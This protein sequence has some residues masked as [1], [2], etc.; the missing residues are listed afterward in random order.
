MSALQTWYS[1]TPATGYVGIQVD[2]HWAPPQA[3]G[4][5]VRTAFWSEWRDQGSPSPYCHAYWVIVHRTSDGSMVNPANPESTTVCGPQS[6][7]GLD[8]TG[9]A[10][11]SLYLDVAVD[12]VTAPART[13]RTV[14]AQLT[15]G[16]QAYL[17]KAI[18][19]YVVP[20][21][22][23]EARWTVDFGDGSSRVFPD[24]GTDSLTTT[25]AY[26]PG[27]FDVT[28][29]V[30]VT[31]EA[32]GAFFTPAGDPFE[33]V[34]PFAIDITNSASGVSA[35][36]V[37]YIA[38]VVTV[39][40]SP[41][42]TLPG[43][44]A[45]PPDD[46]GHDALW[47]PRGLH[48]L[49]YVRPIIVTEGVMRSGGTV[50]GGGTTVLLSYRYERGANDAADAT[51]HRVVPAR[52]AGRGPVGR[53]R[54][55][56]R[57]PGPRAPHHLRR[58]HRPRHDSRGRRRGHRRLRRREP[59]AERGG[60]PVRV[61]RA[62]YVVVFLLAGLVAG[63]VY[64]LGQPRVEV[65]RATVDI[66][67][68]TLVTADMVETV[69]VAP[70][71]APGDAAGSTVEVVGSY[72]AVP[73]LA[74]Q[75][76]DRRA[77]ESTPGER[78]LGFGAPLAAGQVAFALPV[79]PGQAVGAALAPGARVDVVAVPN[80]LKTGACGRPLGEPAGD[81]GLWAR[82][83]SSS[84]SGPPDGQ[85]LTT[86]ARRNAGSGLRSSR[87]SSAASSSPSRPRPR[88]SSRRRPSRRP[89]TSPSRSPGPARETRPA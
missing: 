51:A 59:L 75:A 82:A 64:L 67:V 71:D 13:D 8:G 68:M 61:R 26:E 55:V 12:P 58:R 39:G 23:R 44:T 4:R 17:G 63:G 88:P 28:V 40:A 86:G 43:G 11:M 41:S 72:A 34:V 87:R 36:P 85:P 48:C 73:I 37:D 6:V 78:A 47:W 77:L 65:V 52:L 42:G 25:H 31:G 54:H 27:T 18:S 3:K 9:C 84:P 57:A 1:P 2:G 33:Q 10:D 66:P 15:A 79:E 22:V 32:Y 50:I 5:P 29:T 20:G 30:H 35:L 89:S 76:V 49:V 14:T 83:T 80:A 46:A 74:G 21:S 38:P 19:A 81:G 16:W 45:V 24:N 60:R 69:R 53:A 7:A 56:P 70:A 62:P